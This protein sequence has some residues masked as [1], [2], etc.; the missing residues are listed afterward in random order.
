[1]AS[2]NTNPFYGSSGGGVPANG[3]QQR[4]ALDNLLRREL[5]VGDPNDPK[6]IAQALLERYKDDPRA[7]SIAQEARGLPFLLDAQPQVTGVRAATSCETELKQAVDDVDSDLQELT[8]NTLLKDSASE[9]RGWAQAIRSLIAEGTIA[10]RFG[11]DTRQR[12]KVFSIRRQLGDYARLARMIGAFTPGLNPNFRSFA[13][14]L[15]EVS[16]VFLVMMGEALANVGFNGGRFLLQVP[17]TELQ[18]RRE[19]AIAALRNLTGSTQVSSLYQNDWQ[20][21]LNAYRKL[22]KFLDD[23]G[24]GDLRILLM[25][26]ELAR[27]MDELIQ[28]TAHGTVDGLRA[29]GATAE[30]DLDRFRRL[31]AVGNQLGNDAP[32]LGAFFDALLLFVQSFDA[33]G[34]FRLLR[35]ARPPILHYGLY[36][37]GFASDAEKRL[38]ALI[39][40][41]GSLAEEADCYLQSN[42]ENGTRNQI[43]IDKILYDVDRAI[44][45]Y[46]VGEATNYG[47]PEIRAGAYGVLIRVFLR[48]KKQTLGTD[49]FDPNNILDKWKKNTKIWIPLAE[50]ENTLIFN[51]LL[52]EL[53]ESNNPN[54]QTLMKSELCNQYNREVQ[55]TSGSGLWRIVETIAPNC[56]DLDDIFSKLRVKMNDAI[57]LIDPK[58]KPC[59]ALD[60]NYPTTVAAGVVSIA[61]ALKTQRSYA[62]SMGIGMQLLTDAN[63]TPSV[64]D[65][66]AKMLEI[67]RLV[68]S[69]LAIAK[70]DDSEERTAAIEAFQEFAGRN[71]ELVNNLHLSEN[72][73][74]IIEAF[75]SI[76]NQSNDTTAQTN[77]FMGLKERCIDLVSVIGLGI[78]R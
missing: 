73:K 37:N 8:T 35:I 16:A 32:P 67:S 4:L 63:Q 30:V 25:E 49:E 57:N 18:V 56:I 42:P 59:L 26:N 43:F 66:E 50:L 6:Q 19:S 76:P 47:E 70:N 51:E 55:N 21:G 34:G 58:S 1:M 29:L 68:K 44:D 72:F 77:S 5:R 69:V 71:T 74:K 40:S 54:W 33:A 45:L 78:K 15:D 11:L 46:A 22:Y 27:A 62:S 48:H 23:Q 31:I 60:V 65:D 7:T 13:K 75:N 64:T 52:E 3:G 38:L 53:I 24:Q 39:T 12:D 28:R 61:D 20:W 2:Q 10:A 14:S 41:R 36:G 17:F 9:L